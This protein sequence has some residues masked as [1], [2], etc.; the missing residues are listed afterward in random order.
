MLLAAMKLK[1]LIPLLVLPA[2]L[3]AAG[4]GGTKLG[5]AANDPLHRGAEIFNQRC[6]G[7]HTYDV[8]STE[9]SGTKRNGRE[10]KDGPNFNLRKEQYEEALYAIQN[11]GFSSGPMPQNIV[12]GREAQLVAC[13]VATF[14]G[15]DRTRDPSPGGATDTA[16]STDCRGKIAPK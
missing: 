5:V 9:G 6:G 12:T 4:C 8:A 14:S 1:R 3:A 15:R 13:F 2:A 11:G 16:K 7:C 10:Y